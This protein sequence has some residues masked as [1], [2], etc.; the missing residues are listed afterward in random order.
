MIKICPRCREG[1]PAD[2]EFFAPRDKH[3]RLDGWCRACRSEDQKARY[4]RRKG[5]VTDNPPMVPT[6][7]IVT[8]PAPTPAT[9][10]TA[11]VPPG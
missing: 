8:P 1:L 7:W 6:H 10:A 2:G 4:Q 9:Q 11:P 3:G 5:A